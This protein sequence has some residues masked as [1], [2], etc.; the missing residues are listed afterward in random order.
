VKAIPAGGYVR[1]VGMT[2][3]EE[4]PPEDEARSYRQAT[5]P[6]RILVAVAGSAMH[7]VMAFVLLFALVTLSGLPVEAIAQ[8]SGLEQFAG[9]PS[10]AQ[11]AGLKPGD[12]LIAIDGHHFGQAEQ[13]VTFVRSHAGDE[14][15]LV[16][17]RGS[18][19]VT[20]HVR[21]VDER[22]VR[23]V[24]NGKTER[25][26][27]VPATKTGVIGVALNFYDKNEKTN[28]ITGIGRATTMLGD[29]VGGTA[30]GMAQVF[31]LHGLRSFAHE[32]SVAGSS[33]SNTSTSGSGK[34]GA[35]G[36]TSSS[37]S[38]SGQIMSILGAIQV[39]AQAARQDVPELLYLL[40]AINI[41][42]GMI[43]LFPML[44]LDGG[45]V[46]IAVYERVRSRRGHR[47][48][49]DITKLMPLAYLFLLFMVV[50]GL[51]ALYANIVQPVSLPGG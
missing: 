43:N 21:P 1:I 38:S 51:G 8:V 32:V 26:P 28:P 34:S 50:I 19:D 30:T 23:I 10:P 9:G 14:L 24:V 35:S 20:L 49:A 41:F 42:V 2:M 39:G 4:V 7:F 47:Y 40:A 18:R 17:R 13:F 29:L 31:S 11:Q 22:L 33:S 45:H 44:P 27:G 48:H 36:S 5:F 37:G 46:A 6:R 16:V 25:P 15:S 3:L 12:I